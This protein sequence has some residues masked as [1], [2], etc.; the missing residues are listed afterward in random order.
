[1]ESYSSDPSVMG[2]TTNSWTR[3]S[4]IVTK[5]DP[6]RMWWAQ[7]CPHKYNSAETPSQ[8]AC[9]MIVASPRRT[10]SRHVQTFPEPSFLARVPHS[11]INSAYMTQTDSAQL[12]STYPAKSC[13]PK[14]FGGL[15][16]SGFLLAGLSGPHFMQ[17][18]P[19]YQ[20][21]G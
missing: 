9:L 12:G 7:S 19:Q 8:L 15:S 10:A 3:S 17:C 5:W 16:L 1:M 18:P 11:T 21:I 6:L 4:P 14:P 2:R 13:S 20:K